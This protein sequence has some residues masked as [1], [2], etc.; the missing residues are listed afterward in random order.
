M[1]DLVPQSGDMQHFD[2]RITINKSDMSWVLAAEPGS[3][4]SLQDLEVKVLLVFC[5]N[6]VGLIA[7]GELW[8]SPMCS[9]VT[10]DSSAHPSSFCSV[11]Y[12]TRDVT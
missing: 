8:M 1:E 3:W 10:P 4:S 7:A 12:K 5:I 2:I 6:N 11:S 9:T